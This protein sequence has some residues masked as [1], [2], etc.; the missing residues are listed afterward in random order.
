MN[1]EAR[2]LFFV[3]HGGLIG[4]CTWSVCSTESWICAWLNSVCVG[5]LAAVLL[6]TITRKEE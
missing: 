6:E 5:A 4:W 3:W 2:V 1:K